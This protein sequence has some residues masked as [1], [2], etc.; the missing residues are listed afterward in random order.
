[1]Q[2]SARMRPAMLT[3]CISILFCNAACGRRL[4]DRCATMARD[5]ETSLRESIPERGRAERISSVIAASIAR[6]SGSR[7]VKDRWTD[8][9]IACH[10][11]ARSEEDLKTCHGLLADGARQALLADVKQAVNAGLNGRP[12]ARGTR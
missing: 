10:L 9:V 12:A 1:M 7:C 2:V 5:L 4:E 11:H 3:I 8:Q 6:E